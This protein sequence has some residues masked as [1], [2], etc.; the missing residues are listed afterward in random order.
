MAAQ[1][2]RVI[3]GPGARDRDRRPR[4]LH[5]GAL[6][7]AEPLKAA[8]A[9]EW[10]GRPS[11][12]H[13]K[14]SQARRQA[15]FAHRF[16]RERGASN[17]GRR[18][19]WSQP[20]EDCPAGSV[21]KFR[22]ARR[23]AGQ[24]STK[25]QQP[26]RPRSIS[27]EPHPHAE[28]RQRPTS[29]SLPL[30]G[31]EK[32][33]GSAVVVS[34]GSALR[35]VAGVCAYDEQASVERGPPAVQVQHPLRGAIDDVPVV[36]CDSEVSGEADLSQLACYGRDCRDQLG[37]APR[38][39]DISHAAHIRMLYEAL[40]EHHRSSRKRSKST[41]TGNVAGHER[42]G[43]TWGRSGL[44]IRPGGRRHRKPHHVR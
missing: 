33:H 12:R 21:V 32:V 44:G 13:P 40:I 4:I 41:P 30:D 23:P 7:A 22:P 9:G 31:K 8:V 10:H 24:C 5:C 28:Q 11:L 37:H 26:H 19:A 18:Q 38:P 15:R 27:S 2:D 25:V 35:E 36:P 42:A 29:T 6:L 43:R 16:R 34:A 20:G 39:V 1:T 14:P 3:R 17:S